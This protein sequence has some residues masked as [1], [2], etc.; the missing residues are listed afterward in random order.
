VATR[1]ASEYI[2]GNRK[3]VL[4]SRAVAIT[5]TASVVGVIM[6]ATKTSGNTTTAADTALVEDV[7][8]A[9]ALASGNTTTTADAALVK[10]VAVAVAL[11]TRNTT[12]TADAAL[13]KGVAVAVA[14]ATRNTSTTADTALVKGAAVAVAFAS[15]NTT[16]AADT[17][18]VKGVAVAVAPAS[19]NTTTAAETAH[20]QRST[21][22]AHT[23]AVCLSRAK[24][25]AIAVLITVAAVAH[26]A[27]VIDIA[28]A[29]AILK[30]R[31][32]NG[33]STLE[34]GG[35]RRPCL[36]ILTRWLKLE[37]LGTIATTLCSVNGKMVHTRI[38]ICTSVQRAVGPVVVPPNIGCREKNDCIINHHCSTIAKISTKT[39]A[40]SASV[41][42][43]DGPNRRHV[44]KYSG[45]RT[46]GACCGVSK[47]SPITNNRFAVTTCSVRQSIE[48]V[49]ET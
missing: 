31:F 20:V 8:V 32:S 48:F 11:A 26:T 9:V 23:T 1:A 33:Q 7:A 16:T 34:N 5:D 10:G 3:C 19:G 46:P 22:V 45:R 41:R 43:V 36:I 24:A 25:I 39:E 38:Q 13:V 6:A 40:P 49:F 15:W 28:V 44:V 21:A 4:A 37:R 18:L 42:G 14:L 12:T 17:A 47:H 27:V 35:I 29:V 30:R 2:P